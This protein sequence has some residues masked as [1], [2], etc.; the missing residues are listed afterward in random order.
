MVYLYGFIGLLCGFSLGLGLI[1]VM[2]RSY[3]ARELAQNK[4]LRWTY[5]L[6]VWAFAGIGVYGA[7]WI[8]H[9]HPLF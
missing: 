4:S 2:L 6:F 1:N 9:N 3:S 5:G 8:Y 7:V